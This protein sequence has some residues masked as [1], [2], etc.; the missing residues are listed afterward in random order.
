MTR[1]TG[2]THKNLGRKKCDVKK[3]CLW[4]KNKP[5]SNLVIASLNISLSKINFIKF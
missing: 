4:S 3:D 5:I 1:L 2:V